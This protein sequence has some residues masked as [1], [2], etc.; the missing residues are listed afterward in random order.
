M[1]QRVKVLSP[2]FLEVPTEQ[3]FRT[4]VPRSDSVF[5]IANDDSVIA[6]VQ[7]PCPFGKFSL[8]LLPFC[9]IPDVTLDNFPSSLLIKIADKF[10]LTLFA[11]LSFQGKVFVADKA[12]PLQFFKGSAVSLFISEQSNF[13]QFFPN[14][15]FVGI[16]QQVGHEGVSV[17][18]FPRQRVHNQRAILARLKQAAITKFGSPHLS[19][20][21]QQFAD[22]LNT[23]QNPR[24]LPLVSLNVRALSIIVPPDVFE[25][26][27]Y[28]EIIEKSMPR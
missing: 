19:L 25:S 15:C 22:V 5:C 28:F 6:E 4:F 1:Q 16:A 24:R 2:D 14:Q 9:D 17:E 20:E 11:V 13:E 23:K 10:H 27:G 8:R 21:V 12:V 26:M 18:D 3:L 7:Q